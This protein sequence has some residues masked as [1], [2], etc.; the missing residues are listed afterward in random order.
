[1]G[2]KKSKSHIL[3]FVFYSLLKSDG[4]KSLLLLFSKRFA[5][6]TLFVKNDTSERTNIH[7]CSKLIRPIC[8]PSSCYWSQVSSWSGFPYHQLR[9]IALDSFGAFVCWV[10]VSGADCTQG[11]FRH[12]SFTGN[13]VS[14][15]EETLHLSLIGGG[16]SLPD[17]WG[18]THTQNNLLPLQHKT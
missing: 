8:V 9:W 18:K 1:M 4:R 10:N 16:E 12:I 3:S 13:L 7:P 6:I 14:D 15:W 5:P 11:N 2:F 17:W